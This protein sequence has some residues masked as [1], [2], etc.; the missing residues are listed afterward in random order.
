MRETNSSSEPKCSV[1]RITIRHTPK[2]ALP[3]AQKIEVKDDKYEDGFETVFYTVAAV[4]SRV[5]TA[6]AALTGAFV[7]CGTAQLGSG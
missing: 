5:R 1:L 7:A 3:R 2:Q 6:N 4:V